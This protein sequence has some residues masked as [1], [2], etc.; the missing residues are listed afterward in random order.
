MAMNLDEYGRGGWDWIVSAY[1]DS[2]S[3]RTFL[4]LEDGVIVARC[5]YKK[6]PQRGEPWL[7]S[8]LKSL[9]A[10]SASTVSEFLSACLE[11]R[12]SR[13]PLTCRGK[14]PCCIRYVTAI[15]PSE[16]SDGRAAAVV[17][18]IEERFMAG[19]P[20]P[21]H[22]LLSDSTWRNLAVSLDIPP[23][24]IEVA[25]GVFD[26]LKEEAIARRIEA[27]PHTVHTHLQRLYRRLGVRNRTQ[28]I[29]RV[30]SEHLDGRA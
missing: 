19:G 22:T 5:G 7:G 10:G 25:Q 26:D 17:L 11:G 9:A 6:I 15:R 28:L 2:P 21:G 3:G 18:A 27:S 4:V 29:L 24:K 14:P 13:W 23:R 16:R 20:V 12:P 8:R 30:L 1:F